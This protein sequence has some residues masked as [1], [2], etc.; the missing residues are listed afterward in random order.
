MPRRDVVLLNTVAD[1]LQ[2]DDGVVPQLAQRLERAAQSI[3]SGAA[4]DHLNRWISVTQG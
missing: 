1:G 2:V 3:D 4:H